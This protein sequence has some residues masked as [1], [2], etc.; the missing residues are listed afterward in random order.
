MGVA[1]PSVHERGQDRCLTG[2]RDLLPLCE[3]EG[4]EGGAAWECVRLPARQGVE[5]DR[6]APGAEAEVGGADAVGVGLGVLDVHRAGDGRVEDEAV[7]LVD[8]GAFAA[9]TAQVGVESGEDAVEG[10]FAVAG[11]EDDGVGGEAGAA[12]LPAVF[13][14]QFHLGRRDAARGADAGR[15]G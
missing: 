7:L 8:A 13:Q 3:A 14:V 1:S 4:G 11:G 10:A 9:V 6:A 15:R 2:R 12:V 5:D